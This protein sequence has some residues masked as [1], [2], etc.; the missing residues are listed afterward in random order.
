[1]IDRRTWMAGGG[2]L[3]GLALAAGPASAAARRGVEPHRLLPASPADGLRD[4]MRLYAGLNGSSVFT[5]EGII[6]GKVEGE[7]PR[8]LVG[9]LAV[10]DIRS[11]E[12]EPGLFRGEQKEAMVCLDLGTRRWLREWHNPY[13][14]E[15]Q[16]TIGYV[17]PTNVYYFD[18]T[19]SAMRE[20]PKAGRTTRDWRSSATDVWV[21][22]ARYSS[23]PSS[24][25]EA[26]FPR[27]YAGPERR[28]VDVL[29]YRAR[30]RDFADRSSRSVLSTLAMMS[31]TPWPLWMMMGRRPGGV[32]WH[33]F[34][35]KYDRFTDLPMVN[36]APIEAAYPGFL[37]DPWGFASEP[38]GTAAQLRRLRGEGRL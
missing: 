30:A 31:D 19:G 27:S 29:T 6:Y 18:Q 38:W 17:S 15:L 22:E 23:F 14:D 16:A 3:A 4:F 36:R 21:T 33:G 25:S 32:L 12:V 26:E 9:F 10:L 37:D 28:S 8:P 1:M 34:G 2:A 11:K 20:P 35:Q 5:N 7:L 24:I 13:L